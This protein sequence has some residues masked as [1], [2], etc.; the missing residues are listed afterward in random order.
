MSFG[1]LLFV[2][3]FFSKIEPVIVVMLFW[4]F[5]AQ[6]ACNIMKNSHPDVVDADIAHNPFHDFVIAGPKQH[7]VP[8]LVHL[9]GMESPGLT[10][11]L[12]IA[13]YVADLVTKEKAK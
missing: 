4:S 11:S 6:N 3:L 12:A 13:E 10:C 8:G 9:L 1:V 5:F 7:G 2:C